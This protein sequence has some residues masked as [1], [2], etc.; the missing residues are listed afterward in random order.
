MAP[1]PCTA[2]NC[3]TTFQEG[4]DA[5]VLLALIQMHDRTAHQAAAATDQQPTKAEKVRRPSITSAGTSEEFTYFQQRWQGYKLATKL[6]GR[7]II[8]QLLECLE[9][10]LRKDL[11]RTYGD[12][13][14]QDETSVLGF[15]KTLAVR[16]ENHLVAR[17]QL[18]Q[19]RQDR[20][21]P[22]RSFCARLR[23]QASVCNFKKKCPCAEPQDV[24]YSDDMIRDCLIRNIQDEE[25]KLDVLGQVNQEISL[26]EAL[27]LIEAKE[28]G[29]RSAT[30][31]LDTSTVQQSAAMN[32]NYRRQQNNP[33]QYSNSRQQNNQQQPFNQP[34]PNNQNSDKSQ[35]KPP[36]KPCTHCGQPGHGSWL[37]ERMR[38]C[39][40][41]NKQCSKCG[42]HHHHHTVCRSQRPSQ[43]SQHGSMSQ[44]ESLYVFN[45][46]CDATSDDPV[47]SCNSIVLD[48]HI[49]ENLCNTWKKCRS[50]PQ[51][52]I[53]VSVS[54]HPSDASDLN[55]A[56][57]M[58]TS[59]VVTYSALTDTCCQSSLSGLDLLNKLHLNKSDLY[60]VRMSMTAANNKSINILGALPL[61]ITGVSPS[62]SALTTRQIVYFTDNTSKLFISKQACTELGIIP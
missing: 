1:I 50:D 15:I 37:R 27:Q 49:Y 3:T 7:D 30:R 12:L 32:S 46:L 26:D 28:S 58:K 38:K 43:T 20:D 29:K 34:N 25:I 35:Q 11:T 36:N 14:A 22:I 24:D 53:S 44:N 6:Q 55:L 48:H 21:E 42:I 60:P 9:E 19:L 4:L 40:A 13:T 51:P 39:P 18:Q 2:P 56:V 57:P 17:V 61:R 41:Y 10:P 8:F 16:P 23:G 31:L 59:P 47:D 45:T 62:G 5:Q 52:E 33:Q 54:T